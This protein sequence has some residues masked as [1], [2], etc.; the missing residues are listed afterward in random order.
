MAVIPLTFR[1]LLCSLLLLLKVTVVLFWLGLS[2]PQDFIGSSL[3]LSNLLLIDRLA[4]PVD[5]RMDSNALLCLIFGGRVM[6][7]LCFFLLSIFSRSLLAYC[8]VFPGLAQFLRPA[9]LAGLLCALVPH[10]RRLDDHWAACDDRGVPG[11]APWSRARRHPAPADALAF[12]A[13]RHLLLLYGESAFPLFLS[14]FSLSLSLLILL[15][16]ST[17]TL[18]L[19]PC[20]LE[21]PNVF[22]VRSTVLA[23][24]ALLLQAD[25][26][27]SVV[28]SR[29]FMICLPGL[30]FLPLSIFWIFA[31]LFVFIPLLDEMY[32]LASG[33]KEG[34]VAKP[35]PSPQQH[36]HYGGGHVYPYRT[37]VMVRG[38]MLDYCL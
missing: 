3:I 37:V 17:I 22:A 16:Q 32:S 29:R 21:A 31:L 14:G 11:I 38:P 30:L 7:A 33:C 36:H 4:T 9:A 19:T 24:L 1:D 2:T 10:R 25:W 12:S 35:P 18:L 15:L 6:Q 28:G 26:D 5:P 20:S 8:A 13:Y 23:L 27:P 34:R